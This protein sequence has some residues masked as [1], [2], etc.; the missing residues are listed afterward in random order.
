MRTYLEKTHHKRRAGGVAQGEDP[1]FKS[2]YQKRKKK[3]E[4]KYGLM[5]FPYKNEYR[6]F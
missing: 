1:E 3:K 5:Y 6:N 2:K 4:G